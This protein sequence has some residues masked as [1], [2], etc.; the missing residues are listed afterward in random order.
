[1]NKQD[2]ASKIAALIDEARNI[3]ERGGYQNDD[4]GL[5]PGP[6]DWDALKRSIKK[7]SCR[8]RRTHERR[9]PILYSDSVS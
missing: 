2:A 1:M 6:I 7:L 3:H 9:S 4:G 5:R 8:S